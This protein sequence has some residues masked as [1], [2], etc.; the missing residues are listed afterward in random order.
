MS[1]KFTIGRERTCDFFIADESVSRHHADIWLA[2]DDSLMLADRG[3]SNGTQLIR[4]GQSTPLFEE[5]LLRTDEVRF[6]AAVFPVRDVVDA[7]EGKMPGVLTP[8]TPPPPPP[9]PPLPVA[10]PLPPPPPRSAVVPPTA[11]APAPPPPPAAPPP[12]A[13]L[14]N[15]PTTMDP[16]KPAKARG[17]TSQLLP[18]APPKGAVDPVVGWLVCIEGPDRGRDYR[19][20]AGANVVGRSP[21]MDICIASDAAVSRERHCSINFDIEKEAFQLTPGETGSFLYLNGDLVTAPRYLKQDDVL[22]VGRTKL[23]F[24][25]FWSKEHRWIG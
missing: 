25:A 18:A 12:V 8:K 4:G 9:P 10:P 7:I 6:G 11:P 20:R 13:A 15:I 24:I 23:V 1:Q 2:E 5:K 17:M 22:D 21:A 19:L 16:P 14:P 3:S